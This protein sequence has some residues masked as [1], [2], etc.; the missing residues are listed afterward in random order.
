MA[1]DVS[2]QLLK[3]MNHNIQIVKDGQKTFIY[4]GEALRK[5]RDE[6]LYKARY[7]TF[8]ELCKVEFDYSKTHS[9]RLIEAAVVV[10]DLNKV[11]NNLSPIG[12]KSSTIELKESHARALVECADDAESRAK[13]IEEL[14][15]DGK[16]ITAKSIKEKADEI[17]PPKLTPTPKQKIEDPPKTDKRTEFDPT[18][19][20]PDMADQAESVD[21]SKIVA[22]C[23]QL[24]ISCDSK[25]TGAFEDLQ[26]AMRAIDEANEAG[27]VPNHKSIVGHY[28]RLFKEIEEARVTMTQFVRSWKF[29]K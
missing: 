7:K 4:V 9:Y 8:E 17:L 19:F 5:L 29:R 27:C 28:Q 10:A 3:D 14:E 12:D 21:S 16:P 15:K 11:V 18:K 13:V 6:E 24:V 2:K 22:K 23:D 26:R 25:L 20:D 1:N